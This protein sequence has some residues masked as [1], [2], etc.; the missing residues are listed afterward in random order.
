MNQTLIKALDI[1]NELPHTMQ[2]QIITSS[3]DSE[4]GYGW[5]RIFHVNIYDVGKRCKA[6]GYS[7]FDQYQNDFLVSHRHDW[8][9]DERHVF[10]ESFIEGLNEDAFI[11]RLEIFVTYIK[12][13]NEKGGR[14]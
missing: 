14:Q 6:C 10:A 4:G 12:H 9:K 2:A 3:R 5:F 8:Y 1:I 11:E 13:R 7:T